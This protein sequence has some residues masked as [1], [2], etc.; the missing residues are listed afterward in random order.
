MKKKMIQPIIITTFIILC[1]I[2]GIS[3]SSG[4]FEEQIQRY[5]TTISSLGDTGNYMIDPETILES[6]D[7]GETNV[8]MPEIATPEF[9]TPPDGGTYSW[10]QADYWEIASA[11]HQFV[12]GESVDDWSLFRMMFYTNCADNLRGFAI[13]DFV[14]FKPV[15]NHW[16]IRYTAR[17]IVIHPLVNSISWGGN[18]NYPRPLLGWKSVDLKKLTVTAD[19]AIQIAEENGGRDARLSVENKCSIDLSVGFN[20]RGDGWS[21]DYAQTDG[22][23]IFGI[24]IDPYTGEYKIIDEK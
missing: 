17:E 7:R 3:I 16:T 14:Y 5:P 11:L 12:W 15:L 6:L 22:T 10:S 2:L 8:F 18:R 24:E 13:G 19:D 9:Y 23:P 21:V 1:L 4:L 20:P